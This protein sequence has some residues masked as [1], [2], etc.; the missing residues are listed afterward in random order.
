MQSKMVTHVIYFDFKKELDSV[1]HNKLL[2]KIDACG[3]SGALFNW[4]EAFLYN[5]KQAVKVSDVL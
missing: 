1:S 4:I 3:I 5:L 2:T